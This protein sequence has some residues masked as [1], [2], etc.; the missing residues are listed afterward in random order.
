MKTSQTP[1][2]EE[3]EELAYR[4][5]EERGCPEGESLDDWFRAEQD[6]LG[7]LGP[8]EPPSSDLPG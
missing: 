8:E 3:I 5:W 1:T 6:L 2:R 4:Y 7:L